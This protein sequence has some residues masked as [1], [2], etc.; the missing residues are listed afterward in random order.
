MTWAAVLR[1]GQDLLAERSGRRHYQ[2]L[3]PHARRRLHYK[4]VPN[5]AAGIAWHVGKHNVVTA[6]A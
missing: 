6:V 2:E 4:L 3:P 5:I 1:R